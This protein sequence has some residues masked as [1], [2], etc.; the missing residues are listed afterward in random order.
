M[1]AHY[2]I[3]PICATAIWCELGDCARFASSRHAIRHAGIHITVYASDDH[4]GRGHLS[5]TRPS[6]L[7]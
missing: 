7:R 6:V 4:R 3:G 5:R 1:D 2:G